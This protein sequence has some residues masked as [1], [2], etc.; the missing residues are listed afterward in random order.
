MVMFM[1]LSLMTGVELLENVIVMISDFIMWTI[2][3]VDE[4]LDTPPVTEE[5]AEQI[6]KEFEDFREGINNY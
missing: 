6:W 5:R 1:G 3:F 2:D 4:W